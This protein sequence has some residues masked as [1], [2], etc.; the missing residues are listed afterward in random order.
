MLEVEES[1]SPELKFT[2]AVYIDVHFLNLSLINGILVCWQ[3]KDKT[4]EICADNEKNTV[5]QTDNAKVNY[6]A[7]TVILNGVFAV[8]IV[9]TAAAPYIT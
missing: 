6:S 9:V 7:P 4:K 5:R 8:Q 1:V 3:D 2:C